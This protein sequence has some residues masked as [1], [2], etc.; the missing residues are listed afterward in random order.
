MLEIQYYFV[1]ITP[2]SF[3]SWQKREQVEMKSVRPIGQHIL[4]ASGDEPLST[5]RLNVFLFP[6]MCLLNELNFLIEQTD[7]SL[8]SFKVYKISM[9]FCYVVTRK[10]QQRIKAD[11]DTRSRFTEIITVK[12]YYDYLTLRKFES[13]T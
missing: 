6:L 5:T 9:T 3:G 1:Q 10:M 7:N 8:P 12:L 2:L 13:F 11:Y 4:I